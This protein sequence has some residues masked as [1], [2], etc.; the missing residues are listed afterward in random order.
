[1]IL[2]YVQHLLGI[3]HLRRTLAIADACD[4]NGLEVCVISGGPAFDLGPFSH[5]PIHQLPPIQSADLRFS[6]LVDEH[7]QP[8]NAALESER[9]D[10][11][12]KIFHRVS[13]RIVVTE[14]FP[15]G[16]RRFRFEIEPLLDQA[17]KQGAKIICSVRDCVQHRSEEREAETL[18]F[19]QR[20]YDG[21]LVHGEE[22]FLP[23][24]ASFRRAMEVDNLSYTGFVDTAMSTVPG[25]SSSNPEVLIAAGG[26]AAGE[27]LYEAVA[28]ARR[29]TRHHEVRWR[30]LVGVN[31]SESLMQ[32]LRATGGDGL[33]VE[34]NR[35]DY[36]GLMT[37]CRLSISQAGYNSTVDIL[38]SG[39]PAIMVPFTGEGGE[40]EQPVRASRL[41]ESGRVSLINESNLG[42]QHL[43]ETIDRLLD[44][45]PPRF[46]P[47]CC[48][49]A[50]R[51]AE[52]L[53]NLI[54]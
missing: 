41:A 11:L 23:F 44:G 14:L 25:G 24:D 3:G 15:F 50:T 20:Y 4:Q 31:P 53:K 48:D 54:H 28:N 42:A 36:R 33:V 35:N 1:V 29:L 43:A 16:R 21:V 49:G 32:A 51:S 52:M 18:S 27:V 37:T 26:G 6:S 38:S 46:D 39:A 13:P 30:M 22:G 10:Q 17:Q 45:G 2:F 47:V 8:V 7:G 12:I 40:T 5:L 9:A 19:L 34:P